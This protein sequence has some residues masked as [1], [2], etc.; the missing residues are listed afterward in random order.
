MSAI[1]GILNMDGSRPDFRALHAMRQ[2][3]NYWQPDKAGEWCQGAVALGHCMLWNTPESI[4]ENLP[5]EL[6]IET[7]TVAAI[8][9]DTRLDNRDELSFLLGINASERRHVKDSELL[10]MAWRRWGE[11]CPKYL[12]GDFSF[13][14]WDIEKQKLFCVRD[15]IGI[16]PFHYCLVDGMF[17]FASDIRALVALENVSREYDPDAIALYLTLGELRGTERTFLRGIKKLAPG[18]SM[19]VFAGKVSMKTYWRA[20]NAPLLEFK[21]VQECA[22][23]LKKLLE[24]VVSDRV[25]SEFPVF[26]HLSG[27]LDSSA[28]S[29]IAARKLRAEGRSLGAFSWIH[30]PDSG[31]DPSH[32][33]WANAAKVAQTENIELENIRITAAGI[34]DDINKTDITFGHDLGFWYEAP[35][36]KAVKKKM[37][38]VIL[39]GWGG[40]ELISHYGDVV[41]GELFWSGHIRDAFRGIFSH[42]RR[43]KS[44]FRRAASLAFHALLFPILPTSLRHLLGRPYFAE[45]DYL[46]CATASFKCYAQDQDIEIYNAPTLSTRKLQL[47][48]LNLGYLQCRIESWCAVSWAARLEYRYPLLDKRVVE[49]ALG[50]PPEYYRQQGIGRFIFKAACEEIL[51]DD[52]RLEVKRPELKR[53]ERLLHLE[54]EAISLMANN[55]RENNVK[56]CDSHLSTIID[57][58]TLLDVMMTSESLPESQVYERSVVNQMLINSLRIYRLGVMHSDSEGSPRF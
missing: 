18:S 40:D 32:C 24:T 12:L 41:Y 42:A 15:H 23:A 27:G 2:A 9:S 51:P 20:E 28:I 54:R 49:F 10:M 50:I 53:V 8:T 45:I 21:S 13:V 55:I 11:N 39:S 3:H 35:L 22:S 38:R 37:G 6:L 5:S 46:R 48:L 29:V 16:R 33:E 43:F 7:E 47:S 34:Y 52:I 30:E 17:A 26:T 1:F 31:D 56:A 14:I 44:P 25:K 36:R 4:L 19:M 58:T 57:I